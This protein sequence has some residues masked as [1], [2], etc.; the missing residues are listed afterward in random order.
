M[1]RSVQD[2]EKAIAELPKD[3]LME[4][5]AWYQEF[6]SNAWDDQIERSAKSGKL[7]SLAEQAIADH[8]AGK[9]RK[10]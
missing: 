10:L 1:S 7:D 9:S 3:Q 8:K 4:F 2:I 5:R 6:D